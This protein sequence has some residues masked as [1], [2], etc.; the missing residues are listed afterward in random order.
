[1]SSKKTELL[2]FYAPCLLFIF[3]YSYLKNPTFELFKLAAGESFLNESLKLTVVV[4]G[5][6]FCFYYPLELFNYPYFSFI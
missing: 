5:S 1:M 6:K 4:G 2:S 3:F